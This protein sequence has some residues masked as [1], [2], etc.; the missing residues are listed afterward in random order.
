MYG[1]PHGM[2]AYGQY[3][4]GRH[5]RLLYSASQQPGDE[6]ERFTYERSS[7]RE[8]NM[9]YYAQTEEFTYPDNE[10]NDQQRPSHPAKDAMQ[11]TLL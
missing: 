2:D 5:D 4:D 10:Q 8:D 3:A 6:P 1:Q 7:Q 9:E 11:L